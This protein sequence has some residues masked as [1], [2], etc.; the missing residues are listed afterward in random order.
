MSQPSPSIR[1]VGA[2]TPEERRLVYQLRYKV[3]VEEQHYKIPDTTP[4]RGVYS[5]SDEGA[6]LALAHDGDTP[7]GTLAT[8]SW[9]LGGLDDALVEHLHLLHFAERFSRDSISVMHKAMLLE[10]YRGSTAFMQMVAVALQ[11]TQTTSSRFIF[12][13]CAPALVHF[14]ERLGFRRYAPH[15]YHDRT[16]ILAVPMVLALG[17]HEH[18]ARVGSPVLALVRA[19]NIPDDPEVRTY[20]AHHWALPELPEQVAADAP[21]LQT[22]AADTRTFHLSRSPVF[23]G[24]GEQEIRDLVV[25]RADWR[26]FRRKD[27]IITPAQAE[28]ELHLILDGYVEIA[29]EQQGRRLAIATAG[30]GELLGEIGALLEIPPTAHVLALTNG[31][32]LRLP[33]ERLRALLTDEPRA[34]AIFYRN[35]A[36]LVAER[37]RARSLWITERPP[38]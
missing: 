8:N 23:A 35:L 11:S 6:W 17:D 7:I 33:R 9:R 3:F 27:E 24:L 31:T 19:L 15:F 13:D 32:V 4:E 16:G 21:L 20:L 5:D 25:H 26:P 38:L 37:L 36:R 18:L 1:V 29:I 14:Y 34:A 10:R 22:P 30:P 2:S 28:S 12:C